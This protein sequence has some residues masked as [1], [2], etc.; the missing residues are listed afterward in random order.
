MRQRRCLKSEPLHTE[1]ASYKNLVIQVAP[2]DRCPTTER[3]DTAA[4]HTA[5]VQAQQTA[6]HA[7]G[8]SSLNIR[9]DAL[10]CDIQDNWGNVGNVGQCIT[11]LE[12]AAKDRTWEII[13]GHG[14]SQKVCC[15]GTTEVTLAN[16][17]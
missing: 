9:Q 14:A 2:E 15:H 13:E 4:S 8:L 12:G 16:V 5:S 3:P 6:N 7:R 17:S 10:K 11:W 1:P